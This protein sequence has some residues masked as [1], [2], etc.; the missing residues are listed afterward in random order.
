[1][2]FIFIV[3]FNWCWWSL[4]VTPKELSFFSTM[5]KW[6]TKEEGFNLIV[7]SILK[8][9]FGKFNTFLVWSYLWSFNVF[10][11]SF[12]SRSKNSWLSFKFASC[13]LDISSRIFQIFYTFHWS[14]SKNSLEIISSPLNSMFDLVGEV[15]KCT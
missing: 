6:E 9:V 15:L 14:I 11:N 12:K 3:K 7:E 5:F 1:M 4:W 13:S 8:H 10:F 2:F